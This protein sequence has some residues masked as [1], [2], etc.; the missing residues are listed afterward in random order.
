MLVSV[1]VPI[2]NAE[3]YLV[4]CIDSLVNQT[5]E[6]IEIILVDDGSLDTSLSI[7]M[8]YRNKDERVK[9]FSK[10]NG[11]QGSARNL[12]IRKALGDYIMFV[13][14]DDWVDTNIVKMLLE[15]AIK[16]DSD[17]VICNIQKTIFDSEEIGFFYDEKFKT[18]IIEGDYK[19][20]LFDISTYPV[21]KLIKRE[22][23]IGNDLYFPEHFYEDVAF[24][25]LLLAHAKK[26]SFIDKYLY[27][28]RNQGNSTV[29]NLSLI[30]DRIVC[31]QTLVDGFKKKGKY[32]TYKNDI[33]GFLN[34]RNQVNLRMV[35]MLLNRK[36]AD[37]MEKQN[38]FMKS[39]GYKGAYIPRVSV[40]GSYNLMI[41]GKKLMGL[42]DAA[43]VDGYYGGQAIISVV[44]E[45]KDFIN[46]IDVVHKNAFRRKCLTNDFS[47]RFSQLNS[48]EFAE[49]DYVLVDFL[50]DRFSI[51]VIEDE[52]F[53]ISDAFKDISETIKMKYQ[54]IEFGT[55]EWK[56]RWSVGCE[57]F[58]KLLDKYVGRK[59]II[60][61]KMMLTECYC[62]DE[63]IYYF[64]NIE[65]IKMINEQLRN[66][67]E[68]FCDRCP[69]AKIVE[70]K[71]ID[72]YY[73][74][75]NYR[76]GCYPWH[77]NGNAYGNIKER[78]MS[79]VNSF[80]DEEQ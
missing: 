13:D 79:V 68:Y 63:E 65:E 51:G 28:Y 55:E 52:L 18:E 30:Y 25:P 4:K 34:Q 77:L 19:K 2:Y 74:D 53:T 27:T 10:E 72:A 45:K 76:H 73:T 35:K 50:E 69:E 78:I 71:D 15:G 39:I 3:K 66:C 61:V 11:G 36:L 8:E 23:F 6:N 62:K 14:A 24:L 41:V 21:A 22:V 44:S 16:K 5:Y 31:M 64:D 70:V 54:I 57:K 42:E 1:V 43:T 48:G 12:G 7:C 58:I 9:V 38:S 33:V 37:F 56:K 29:N 49:I 47:K 75:Y 26:I 17:V 60:L 67:Y 40:F 20:G 46:S 80:A 32:D 59:N